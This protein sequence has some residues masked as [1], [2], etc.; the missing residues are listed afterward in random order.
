MMQQDHHED[1]ERNLMA[2]LQFI[3][4]AYALSEQRMAAINR[5]LE[6]LMLITAG[7]VPAMV[8]GAGDRSP[9]CLWFLLALIC[10]VGSL[11]LS[12]LGRHRGG[13]TEV[14]DLEQI[15]EQANIS[16]TKWADWL[17]RDA[18]GIVSDNAKVNRCKLRY[19]Y[20]AALCTMAELVALVIWILT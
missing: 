18:Q 6:G 16:Q 15:A 10:A 4:P 3:Y 9:W 13:L 12:F 2:A 14:D 1:Y 8:I 11:V 17:L 5:R 20:G 19:I 7:S